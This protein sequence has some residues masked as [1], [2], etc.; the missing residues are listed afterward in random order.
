M[1]NNVQKL[2]VFSFLFLKFSYIGN[3]SKSWKILEDLKIVKHCRFL[4]KNRV[5]YFLFHANYWLFFF[6]VSFLIIVIFSKC[7]KILDVL[8]KSFCLIIII[9]TVYFRFLVRHLFIL[10]LSFLLFLTVFSFLVLEKTLFL[11]A[12]F[13]SDFSLF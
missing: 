6:I 4:D 10:A 3:F 9:I 12:V 11:F 2:L 13:R 7:W 5:F 1:F 8:Y